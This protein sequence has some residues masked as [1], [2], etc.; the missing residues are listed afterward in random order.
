M[1]FYFFFGKMA[2]RVENFKFENKAKLFKGGIIS[3]GRA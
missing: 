3:R 2:Q 1:L